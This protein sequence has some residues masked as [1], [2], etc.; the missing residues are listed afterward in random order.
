MQKMMEVKMKNKMIKILLS[1]L[2]RKSWIKIYLQWKI[3]NLV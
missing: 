1:F 2:E 3:L